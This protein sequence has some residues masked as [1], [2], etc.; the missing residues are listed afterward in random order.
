MTASS[1]CPFAAKTENG[2]IN[3]NETVK[4]LIF[5]VIPFFKISIIFDFLIRTV[6]FIR[7][8]IRRLYLA[9]KSFTLHKLIHRRF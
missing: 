9:I 3:I 7:H 1:T 5:I 4:N 8:L 2:K 6:L